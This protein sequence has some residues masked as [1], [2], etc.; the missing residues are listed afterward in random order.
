MLLYNLIYANND[1]EEPLY[2][3]LINRLVDY[4]I[5]TDLSS[6]MVG[7]SVDGLMLGAF[8]NMHITS[9]IYGNTPITAK[10][11]DYIQIDNGI[12]DPSNTG[13]ITIETKKIARIMQWYY[14]C[15]N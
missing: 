14:C 2:H 7:Y 3:D 15:L 1:T 6:S 9:N 13:S 4:D 8:E 5:D 10:A 12:I 11:L